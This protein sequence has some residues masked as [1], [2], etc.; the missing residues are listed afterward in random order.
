MGSPRASLAG[1]STYIWSSASSVMFDWLP[2]ASPGGP[3]LGCGPG[4]SC[5]SRMS[6]TGVGAGG[7]SFEGGGFEIQAV[8]NALQVVALDVLHFQQDLHQPVEAIAVLDQQRAR[9]LVRVV[10]EAAHLFVDLLGDLLAVVPLL[11]D[12]AAEEDQF[13]LVAERP[14]ARGARSCPT[15]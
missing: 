10:D 4:A 12:L 1:A 15:A 13:L 2:Q 6:S 3:S 7:A 5:G 8:Q 14:R 9:G 11:A